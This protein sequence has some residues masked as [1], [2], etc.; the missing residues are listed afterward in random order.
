MAL[1]GK[2]TSQ[3][4]GAMEGVVVSAKK[5]GSTITVSVVSDKQGT[6]G[7]PANRLEPGHYVLAI[8]AVGYDLDGPGT[9]DVAA[10]KTTSLDLQLRKTKDLAS[11]LTNAEWLISIPGTEAQKTSFLLGNCINCHTLE[12][13]IR[14]THTADEFVKVI[15]RMKGYAQT[16]QPIKPQRSPE[17]EIARSVRPE[18][19]RSLAHYLATVN[20]SSTST[21]EYPLKTLPRPTGRSTHVIITEYGL[22]RPTIMPHDVMLDEHGTVW[23]SDFG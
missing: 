20:L 14:S 22:P 18:D 17:S 3:E 21:W 1:S 8:R 6:F 2:V 15:T 23:F 4:E 7:F 5:K 16:S 9:A 10:H 19:Y 13:P 12:R 11:Q